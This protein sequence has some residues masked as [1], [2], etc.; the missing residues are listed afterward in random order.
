MTVTVSDVNSTYVLSNQ[1][2]SLCADLLDTTAGGSPDLAYVYPVQPVIDCCPALI[3]FMPRLTEEQT[4]PLTPPAATGHRAQFGRVNLVTLTAWVLRCS[5]RMSDDG[6]VNVTEVLYVAQQVQ[7][8]G[9]VL[10]NGIYH[11]IRDGVF[12][13]LCEDVHFGEARPIREQGGCLG[14]EF[15]IRAELN[16]YA[17]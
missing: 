14:W 2:L 11:A 7:Q 17:P 10:W 1:Y 4:S 9:W 8:D 5:P 15:T 16:G 13:S 6:S 3:V 12:K